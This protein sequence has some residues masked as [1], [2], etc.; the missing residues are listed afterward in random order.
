MKTATVRQVQHGLAALLDEVSK[1][2]EIVVTKRG[3][4]IAKIVPAGAGAAK[5]VDWPDSAARLKRLGKARGT[6]PS[7]IIRELRVDRF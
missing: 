7:R 5:A 2:R 1:G 6:P 4:V 3:R